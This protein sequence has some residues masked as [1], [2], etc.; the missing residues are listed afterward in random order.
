MV[1]S[2]QVDRLDAVFFSPIRMEME[3]EAEIQ[4]RSCC[5]PVWLSDCHLLCFE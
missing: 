1:T 3:K 4:V 5:S 2:M